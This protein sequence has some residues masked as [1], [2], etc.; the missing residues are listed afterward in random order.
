MG[1]QPQ[2]KKKNNCLC[3]IAHKKGAMAII[4]MGAV[5][6]CCLLLCS[7]WLQS[8]QRLRG[9][10]LPTHTFQHRGEDGV[11]VST[12]GRKRE[13]KKRNNNSTEPECR[14][15]G[16]GRETSER[17]TDTHSCHFLAVKTRKKRKFWLARGQFLA[18]LT[19]L[20]VRNPSCVNI[21]QAKRH[22]VSAVSII[23][24]ISRVAERKKK[25]GCKAR[26]RA[27]GADWKE[28]KKWN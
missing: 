26:A 14:T 9:R 16:G 7:L 28:K 10:R 5:R 12:K 15:N 23:A 18:D 22:F 24:T 3:W 6:A 13:V 2:I 20:K 4:A 17:L 8:C 27:C 25:W 21:Q 19:T 1:V 11:K